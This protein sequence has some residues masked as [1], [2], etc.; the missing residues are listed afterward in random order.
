M[1]R[2]ADIKVSTKI[3]IVRIESYSVSVI[4]NPLENLARH[5]FKQLAQGVLYLHSKGVVHRDL[6][7]SNIV[8]NEGKSKILEKLTLLANELRIIDFNVAEFTGRKDYYS[9]LKRNNYIMREI[10]GTLKYS[11]PE[12]YLG[13]EYSELIDSWSMGCILYK[14]VTGS[15]PFEAKK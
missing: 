4:S 7:C 5:I 9:C 11:A 13:K 12:I 3:S 6:K 10:T 15:D 14:L 8:V 1:K 2:T